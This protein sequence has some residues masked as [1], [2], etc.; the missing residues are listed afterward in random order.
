MPNKLNNSVLNSAW[1][2]RRR[3]FACGSLK[4]AGVHELHQCWCKRANACFSR[5]LTDGSKMTA[6]SGEV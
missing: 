2:A 5:V 4:F 3:R 6:P 1:K